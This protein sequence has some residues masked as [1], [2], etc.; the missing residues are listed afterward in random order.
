[1]I[2]EETKDRY[3]EKLKDFLHD[4]GNICGYHEGI[5][6]WGKVESKIR[7]AIAIIEAEEIGDSWADG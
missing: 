2:D 5:T 7:K 3:I 1:M 6:C 4:W